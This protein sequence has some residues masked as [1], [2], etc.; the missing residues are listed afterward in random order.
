MNA[1]EFANEFIADLP[2]TLKTHDMENGRFS[3][4]INV[5]NEDP[6]LKILK[7][8]LNNVGYDLIV[9]KVLKNVWK[10]NWKLVKI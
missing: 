9:D 5:Y 4:C 3:F 8:K 6:E 7:S 10:Q 1:E 2:D